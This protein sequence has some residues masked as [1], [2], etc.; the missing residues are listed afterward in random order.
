MTTCS[1]CDDGFNESD[2]IAICNICPRPFHASAD[3]AGVSSS[4]IEVLEFEGKKK[5]PFLVYK[6]QDCTANSNVHSGISECI[7]SLQESMKGLTEAIALPKTLSNDVDALRE[8][9]VEAQTEVGK[10][11]A[12]QQ[13]LLQLKQE[14]ATRSQANTLSIEKLERG[15]VPPTVMSVEDISAEMQDRVSRLNNL[16]MYNVKEIDANGARMNDLTQVQNHLRNVADI[17]IQGIKVRRIGQVKDGK[18]RP[19]SIELRSHHDVIRV[20]GSKKSLPNGIS[21][22]SDKTKAQRA[23]LS[24]LY[25]EVSQINE[26]KGS[27]V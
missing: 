14:S 4:E 17:T 11:P 27:R 25:A 22:A 3:C 8:E 20:M 5:T 13:D 7:L 21:V 24:S 12:I 9:V 2:L 16:I 1:K 18:P 23:H 6:C 19:I 26:E 15:T 10:I